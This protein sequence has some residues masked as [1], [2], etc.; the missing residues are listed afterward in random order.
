MVTRL[1]LRQRDTSIEA[2]RQIEAEG[3]LSRRRWQVYE[4]LYHYGP[5]T[6]GEI[7]R[8]AIDKGIEVKEQTITPRMAELRERKVVKEVGVKVCSTT[9]RNCIAW[10]VTASLPVYSDKKAA[11]PTPTRAEL[12]EA[13]QVLEYWSTIA[14]MR[15]EPACLPVER[16][17]AWIRKKTG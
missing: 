16:L 9:G 13:L 2:Y 4:I 15:G 17:L 10:D 7:A 3:L 12:R 11:A 1:S 5:L 14:I 6:A 8:H